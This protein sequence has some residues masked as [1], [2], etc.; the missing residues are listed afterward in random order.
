MPI[1]LYIFDETEHKQKCPR[2]YNEME[3]KGNT[4]TEH[5]QLFFFGRKKI[6]NEG[7]RA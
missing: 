6:C 1:N 5:L 4:I 2:K 7:E 3:M